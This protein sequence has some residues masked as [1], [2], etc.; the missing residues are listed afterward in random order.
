MRA[1]LQAQDLY[2]EAVLRRAYEV[3][4]EAD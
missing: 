1:V 2:P 3:L 4:P